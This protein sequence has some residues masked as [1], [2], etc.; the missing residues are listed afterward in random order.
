[1]SL[2]QDET[3]SYY[4]NLMSCSSAL[5]IV[6]RRNDKGLS[7]P[8]LV[9][10][11]F[12]ASDAYLERDEEVFTVPM[13][14]E[15]YRWIEAYVL[16][17]YVPQKNQAK[18]EQLETDLAMSTFKTP[19]KNTERNT[20]QEPILSRGP[21]RKQLATRHE[22]EEQKP[23]AKYPITPET[24]TPET[25]EHKIDADMPPVESINTESNLSDF[26]SPEV[27]DTLRQQALR[28]LFHIPVYTHHV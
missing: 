12:D 19:Y 4:Y 11:N 25:I 20:T 16:G 5:Y 10:A 24:L 18:P 1:M 21:R 28:K 17:Y 13:S 27:S 26:F 15:T 14:A 8:F 23:S 3:E 2:F 22:L 7:E 6:T 9:T